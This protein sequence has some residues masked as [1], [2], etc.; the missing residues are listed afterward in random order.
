M[1]GEFIMNDIIRVS[2]FDEIGFCYASMALNTIEEK[3]IFHNATQSPEFK[4]SDF[5]N[6]TFVCK[7][8]LMRSTIIHGDDG[9]DKHVVQTIFVTPDGKGILS[10]S[11]GVFKS[12][13]AIVNTFGEPSEWGDGLEFE[14]KET[15]FKNGRYFKVLVV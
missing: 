11:M 6:K 7:D 9:E 5:I 3:K 8:I 4:A 14:I 1:K 13:V 12:V 10:N 2:D 15:N